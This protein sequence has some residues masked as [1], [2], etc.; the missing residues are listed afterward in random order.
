MNFEEKI[1]CIIADSLGVG[2]YHFPSTPGQ[3][4]R[5]DLTVWAKPKDAIVVAVGGMALSY[6][7]PAVLNMKK[8]KSKWPAK[9]RAQLS[10]AKQ[11]NADV[12]LVCLGM[13]DY[14]S[15]GLSIVLA[16]RNL[17]AE[18]TKDRGAIK[19]EIYFV[20]PPTVLPQLREG[21]VFNGLNRFYSAM[22]FAF[23]SQVFDTRPQSTDLVSIPKDRPD[24][25]HFT[26]KAAE[27]YAKRTTQLLL[28]VKMGEPV[29]QKLPFYLDYR[30]LGT[31]AGLYALARWLSK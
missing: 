24:G 7:R 8:T 27:I 15:P 10:Y 25:I 12:Y 31:G 17:I 2:S 1:V 20:G 5:K 19:P 9:A 16:A 18:L 3:F 4:L 26:K 21:K 13:N 11:T 23:G 29:R 6:Y 30:V 14:L 22:Q 28:G